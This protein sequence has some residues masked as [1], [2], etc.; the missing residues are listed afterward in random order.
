M[1]SLTPNP[2]SGEDGGVGGFAVLD[3]DVYRDPRWCANCAGP[4]TFVEIYEFEGGRVG[5]CMGCGE[6]RIALFT[7]TN[8]EA[9]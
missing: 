6:E 4:Q 8:S 5:F 1:T 9:A 2:V 7:R 3:S